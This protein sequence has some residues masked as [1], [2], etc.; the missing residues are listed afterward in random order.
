M[1]KVLRKRGRTDSMFKCRRVSET[2]MEMT[3]SIV[4]HSLSTIMN[5]QR[6]WSEVSV[7]HPKYKDGDRVV[8]VHK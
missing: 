8:D 1:E 2:R 4:G 6:G 3:S 7:R 5:G